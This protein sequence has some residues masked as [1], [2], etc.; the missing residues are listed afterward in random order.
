MA[1]PYYLIPVF[2]G[3]ASADDTFVVPNLSVFSSVILSIA[4]S[5][6]PGSNSGGT[7]VCS[8]EGKDLFSD[9]Y[10]QLGAAIFI[11]GPLAGGE[12]SGQREATISLGVYSTTRVSISGNVGTDLLVDIQ[13]A[14]FV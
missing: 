6:V 2:S 11:E 14:A 1:K 3:T 8:L 13:I 9:N 4:A 7:V 5:G 10:T 12:T